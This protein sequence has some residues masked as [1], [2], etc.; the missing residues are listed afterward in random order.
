MGERGKEGGRKS[1]EEGLR[2]FAPLNPLDH[3]DKVRLLN[4]S[5]NLLLVGF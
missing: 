4:G 2:C 1:G 5:E 3:L